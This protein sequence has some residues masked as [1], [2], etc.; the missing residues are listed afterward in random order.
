[1]RCN[2]STGYQVVQLFMLIWNTTPSQVEKTFDGC[3]KLTG[4]V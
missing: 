1:M 2:G 4:L 3:K